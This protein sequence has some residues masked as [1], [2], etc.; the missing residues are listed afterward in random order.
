MSGSQLSKILQATPQEVLYCSAGAIVKWQRASRA[1]S[2]G[3]QEGVS[4]SLSWLAC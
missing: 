1:P 2:G 3:V 4:A